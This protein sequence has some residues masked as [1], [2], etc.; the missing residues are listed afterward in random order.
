MAQSVRNI[1]TQVN[2]AL[3]GVFKGSTLYGVATLV[4][5]DGRTVPVVDE[6]SVGYDD[7]Y[8]LQAYHRLGNAAVTYSGGYGDG[9]NTINTFQ[10][11]MVVF[12]NEKQTRLKTDEIAMIIQSVLDR[13]SIT[14]ASITL[15]QIILNSQQIFATEYRGTPYALNEYQS[16]MQINYSVEITLKSGCF[17]LC[18]EDFSKCATSAQN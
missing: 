18:P 3:A 7:S 5:R 16:L 2:E 14:S 11:S 12:N 1:I 8:A 6:R 10:V 13:L 15:T 9:T 4:E 17:D